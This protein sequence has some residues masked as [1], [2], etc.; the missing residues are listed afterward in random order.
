MY[1]EKTSQKLIKKIN[2]LTDDKLLD[3]SKLKDDG[4]GSRITTSNKNK[5]KL[6]SLRVVS[7]DIFKIVKLINI[8]SDKSNGF[9]IEM[10]LI[11]EE[12][13]K[14]FKIFNENDLICTSDSPQISY[15]RDDDSVK[16]SVHWGQ[17]KLFLSEVEFFTFYWNPID[18]PDPLCVYA[19]AAPGTHIPLLSELFPTFKFHLYDP[20]PF[21]IQPTKQIKIFKQ[22][23]DKEDVAKYTNKDNVFFICDIRT[24]NFDIHKN[25]LIKENQLEEEEMNQKAKIEN[26]DQIWS[27]MERQENWVFDM[28]PEHCLLKFRLPYPMT[29]KEENYVSYLNGVPLWQVWAPGRSTETRL[30][31]NRNEQGKYFRKDWGILKYEQQCY[32]FN[33]FVR[34]NMKFLNP[35]NS[36]E[37]TIDDGELINDFDSTAEAFI[38][39]TYVERF[40]GSHEVEPEV[41]LLSHKLTKHINSSQKNV[42]TLSKLRTS[43]VKSVFKISKQE[44]VKQNP[45]QHKL[46]GM[47][48]KWRKNN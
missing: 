16:T 17:R 6:D 27:D 4:T 9:K 38:L 14:T 42:L 36:K 47:N 3:I 12:L 30:K 13:Q 26:E 2:S 32:F 41:K 40:T 15:H 10:S 21:S 5:I 24:S 29:D 44:K 8:L 20:A 7:N 45:F 33:T 46:I 48:S 34:E 18:I 25:K 35:L 11:K 28:N 1:N 39:K 31:P 43:A 19:G 23:F 37:E 22:Y